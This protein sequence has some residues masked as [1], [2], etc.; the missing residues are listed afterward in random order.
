M[1]DTKELVE[2]LDAEIAA[3]IRKYHTAPATSLSSFQGIKTGNRYQSLDLR[4]EVLSG[5]RAADPQIYTGI[6]LDG[7]SLVDLGCNTGEKTRYA[8]KAGAEFAEGIEYEDLFVR[9]GNLVNTYNRHGNVVLRQGDIT[10]PGL[11][12][13]RYDVGASFSSFV[14]LRDTLPEILSHIDSMFILETHALT[15]GWLNAYV[16]PVT[17]QM[18]HWCFYGITD[19]GSGHEQG[20]R[21]LLLFA[22]TPEF[23]D[24][25]IQARAG[26]LPGGNAVVAQIDVEASVMPESLVGR[27]RPC[28]AIFQQARET[29]AAIP[30]G[31]GASMVQ[32]LGAIGDELAA[33]APSEEAPLFSSDSYWAALFQGARSYRANSQVDGENPLLRYLLRM[34][35]STEPGMRELLA[36]QKSAALRVTER[37]DGFLQA[38]TDRKPR[39][40]LIAFNPLP[41]DIAPVSELQDG[42][43]N[44]RL[45]DG[46]HWYLQ[47]FDGN[48]R[49][50]ASWLAKVPRVN[51]MFCWTNMAGLASFNFAGLG[52]RDGEAAIMQ[53]IDRAV[54]RFAIPA[55]RD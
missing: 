10:L 40:N 14:Y 3:L 34:A 31:D 51:V 38:I 6:P 20:R 44:F 9:I 12:Q 2:S 45:T 17:Q 52:G 53:M 15:E 48:H 13:R 42:Y 49:L 50:A 36:D 33:A 16:S 1:P 19:H 28:R 25:V 27:I 30:P 54:M 4:G 18:P 29:I 23:L 5:F 32:A 22:K 55:Q 26:L 7:L 46:S 11:L 21:G 8:A 37:L 24:R 41:A 43:Q 39:D 47:A 35:S